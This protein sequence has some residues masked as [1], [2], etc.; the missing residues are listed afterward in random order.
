MFLLA[1]QRINPLGTLFKALRLRARR[2]SSP[3]E[4]R[5]LKSIL[6]ALRWRFFSLYFLIWFIC[7]SDSSPTPPEIAALKRALRREVIDRVL[8]LAPSDRAE[9][10][11]CMPALFRRLPGYAEAATVL[12][13]VGALPEEIDTRPILVL[14]LNSGKRVACPRV[15][16]RERRLVLHEIHDPST[17]LKPGSLGIPEPDRSLAEISPPE[18]DW[19][20]VPGVAFDAACDRL[21]RGAGYYDRLLPLLKQTAPRWA[22]AF[23]AQWVDLLPKEPHDQTLDGVASPMRIERSR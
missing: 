16:R 20:L 12:L 23:D 7:L 18:I 10:E 1:N 11:R 19:A 3:L 22:L 21:G 5:V 13:Y 6:T 17:D 8:A 2:L 9:Q 15:N 4:L 14:A